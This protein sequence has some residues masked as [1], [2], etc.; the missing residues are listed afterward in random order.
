MQE[1]HPAGF[2]FLARMSHTTFYGIIFLYTVLL[3]FQGLDLGDEG[4]NSVFYRN[5]FTHPESVLYS[6]VFWFNGIVGGLFDLAFPGLGLW[7]LRFL[8][9]IS[10]LFTV[11]LAH[12]LLEKYLDK[13]WLRIGLLFSLLVIANN[14]RIFHYNY[15][16]LLL[17]MLCVT[18][19]HKGLTNNRNGWLLAA[20]AMVALEMLTRIPSVVNLGLVIVIFFHGF[21][22]KIPLRKQFAGATAFLAGFVLCLVAMLVVMHFLGHLPTFRASMNLIK[23]M[24]AG[25]ASS[26]YGISKL[27][28]QFFVL[29]GSAVKHGIFFATPVI[30]GAILINLLPAQ[31]RYRKAMVNACILMLVAGYLV[32]VA[33]NII[34]HTRMVFLFV[35]IALLGTGL[36]ILTGK[37]KP[38]QV[39]A[40][41]GA[42][43]VLTYPLGSSDGIH[44]VGMYTFILALPI[45]ID[46]FARWTRLEGHFTL[47]T[48]PRQLK[49]QTLIRKEQFTLIGKWSVIVIFAALLYQAYYYPFFDTHP[50][51]KMTH[52][53][54]NKFVKAIY[55]T[56]E[57]ADAIDALL[58][59]SSKYIKP[60]D[61]VL[62]YHT[63]PLLHYMTETRPYL[64]NSMPWL[65]DGRFFANELNNT[66]KETGQLPVI[67]RQRIKTVGEAATWPD[68]P[69]EPDENWDQLNRE[70]DE[71]LEDFI[72]RYEYQEVWKNEIF[73]I[74]ISNK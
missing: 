68:P 18:F 35:D 30:G 58:Q 53:V 46:Y 52:V 72:S 45:A 6:F 15:Q 56:R 29:Y 57:R 73:S 47:S 74:L 32:A 24:S 43:F 34:H 36:I 69:E 65:Y 26:H 37:N 13:A 14:I 11:I 71:A 28:R 5:I 9:C 23:E 1:Y 20:G 39:L 33:L 41:A 51:T 21:L 70:R 17:F 60:G 22:Y 40:L 55:T 4:L 61:A 27:L 8:G 2:R 59:E 63:I 7:G 38:I 54:N 25:N 16:C 19:L 50:R 48:I 10:L 49:L 62:M 64:H 31:Y 3:S 44:T 66:A 42:Y 12:R 67:I